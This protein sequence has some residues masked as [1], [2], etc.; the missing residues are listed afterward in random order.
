MLKRADIMYRKLQ[1]KEYKREFGICLRIIAN[2][3]EE[4]K[5]NQ[6]DYIVMSTYFFD[7]YKETSDYLKEMGYKVIYSPRKKGYYIAWDKVGIDKIKKEIYNNFMFWDLP[8]T[9]ILVAS[10]Y[11]AVTK[12]DSIFYIVVLTILTV[13]WCFILASDSIEIY[14]CNS[15]K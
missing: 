4:A 11:L 15:K 14:Q 8:M 9:S 10:W 2:E 7:K 5:E 12:T 1:E 3:I 13:L 6:E